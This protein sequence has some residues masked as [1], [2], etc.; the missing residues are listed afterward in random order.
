M[1]SCGSGRVGFRS[2]GLPGAAR[3]SVNVMS[4]TK[5][6]VGMIS[7]SRRMTYL[8]TGLRPSVSRNTEGAGA[9][10][11]PSCRRGDGALALLRHV[12]IKEVIELEAEWGDRVVL[13]V[14]LLQELEDRKSVV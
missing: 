1:V 8:S 12:D 4:A 11:A 10:P 14:R 3:A 5:N 13:H 9:L 7:R 6:I 2:K